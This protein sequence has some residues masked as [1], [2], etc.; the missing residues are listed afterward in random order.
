MWKPE[1]R[2]I[3]RYWNGSKEVG[4]DPLVLYRALMGQSESDIKSDGALME[5]GDAE[6]L[7]RIV[8]AARKVFNVEE[9]HEENGEPVGL[10]ESEVLQLLNDFASWTNETQKKMSLQTFSLPT[11]ETSSADP[12][13]TKS[14]SDCGCAGIAPSSS[15]PLQSH[16]VSA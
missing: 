6:A 1:E 3:Y 5:T 8:A 11:A 9:F 4:A 12:S 13:P 14:T 15:E 7:G 16:K 2:L 10:L